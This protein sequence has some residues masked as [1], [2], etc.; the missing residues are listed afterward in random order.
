VSNWIK[1]VPA[2]ELDPSKAYFLGRHDGDEFVGAWRFYSQDMKGRLCMTTKPGLAVRIVGNEKLAGI[3]AE[4]PE[5]VAIEVPADA[6][7]RWKRRLKR[8]FK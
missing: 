8:S 2:V 4:R 3:L 7:K 1:V 5:F 6:D